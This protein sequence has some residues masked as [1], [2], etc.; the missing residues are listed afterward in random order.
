MFTGI[1]EEIGAIAAVRDEGSNRVL[2]VKA[3]MAPELQVDQSVSHN[4]ACLTV[5]R[6]LGNAYEVVA[7]QET[8]ARTN[9]GAL[10][11][12]DAVNLERSLRLG[13]RLDGHLVQGHVDDVLRCID[14]RDENGSW[15]FRF[16][17]PPS[18]HLL[19][20][21]GSICLNG[22]S[23]TIAQLNDDGFA[24]AIIPYTFEHTT[25]RSLRAGG[26]VNVEYDVLGKYVERMMGGR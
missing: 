10:H 15:T 23:L 11:V 19:V 25:F 20:P 26:T 21:K 17:L 4:G 14:V 3:R 1:V 22:V 5:T 18:K 6:V 12:G 16:A 9:L 8:L 24:V 7:V 2:T 13:D